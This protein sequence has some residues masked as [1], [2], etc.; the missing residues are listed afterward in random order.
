MIASYRESTFHLV[1]W[2]YSYESLRSM[3]LVEFLEIIKVFND[4]KEKEAD[5]AIRAR[6]KETSSVAEAKMSG[7]EV[8][9]QFQ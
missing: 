3:P 1:K 4:F 2:G 9:N 8:P 7:T 6:G 5:A